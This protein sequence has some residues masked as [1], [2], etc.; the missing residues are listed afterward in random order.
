MPSMTRRA[1]FVLSLVSVIA[2]CGWPGAQ[3]AA[4]AADG[5]SDLAVTVSSPL[6]PLQSMFEGAAVTLALDH[7]AMNALKPARR[8]LI[9]NFPLGPNLA[10]TLDLKAIDAF[11]PDAKI[12]TAT[13]SGRGRVIE[14][15]LAMPDVI[16]L[17]GTV[18]GVADSQAFI[19]LSESAQHGWV[20][21]GERM[22]MLSSGPF[23][24][25]MPTMIYDTRALPE[26]AITLADVRCGT[27]ELAPIPNHGNN[28]PA[29]E[30]AHDEGGV[31]GAIGG[32]PVCREVRIAF[33]T[34]YEFTANRFGGDVIAAATYA[35]TMM[36][37]TSQIYTA[38]LNTRLQISFLRLWTT[39]NDPWTMAGSGDQLGEF[40]DYWQ[41]NQQGTPRTLA[42]LVSARGLGGGVAWV[43]VMCDTSFG[44]AVSGNI[45]GS[46]PYPIQNNSSQNW[47]LMVFAHETGHNFSSPHTHNYVPPIDGC[48]NTPNDCTLAA[49]GTIMSYCH[50][51]S[52][53]IANIALTLHPTVNAY[54]LDYL[55][56]LSCDFAGSSLPPVAQDDRGY[57]VSGEAITMDVLKNDLETNCDAVTINGFAATTANGGGI[58]LSSGTGPGG[59]DQLTYTA[60][61]GGGF[62]GIDTFTYSIRDAANQISNATVSIRVYG[63]RASDNPVRF[64]AGSR[65]RYYNLNAPSVLPDFATLVPFT[66]STAGGINFASTGGNFAGSGIADNV[67]AVYTGWLNVPTNGLYTLFLESDDGSR[68]LVGDE[69]VVANDGLH[70]MVELSGLIGLAA[71]RHRVR[72]EF[73]EAGGGAGLIARYSGPG[74]GKQVIP[75]ANWSRAVTGDVNESGGVDVA[76]LLN[77]IT[78]WGPC[79]AG[80]DADTNNDGQINVT[81][82][83]AV[84]TN[85]G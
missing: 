85:W 62:N 49:Q 17:G 47:D 8:A 28:Q 78:T 3:S 84:I 15:P 14:Q 55:D 56:G 59:R 31:A 67:G 74:L 6:T 63:F 46:F 25:N 16:L 21:I 36:A 71:G 83:L 42:H 61:S 80:C 75:A 52:G 19:S 70:G 29:N 72:I 68:L 54:V 65:A 9:E 1:S 11:A 79:T 30:K 82:L 2:G 4:F 5:T 53:G 20:R 37:A 34:D 22:F 18:A 35:A 58:A 45:N 69:V 64:Q 50:L 39:P 41:A 44:Y 81:D 73:F 10:V 43:G 32:G 27:D 51:C 60:P 76:D 40:R 23:G 66:T 12:V 33:D 77:V 38:D 7:A 48:G 26:G 57:V 24:A 13:M